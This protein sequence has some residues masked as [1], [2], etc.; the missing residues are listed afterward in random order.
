MITGSEF[1]QKFSRSSPQKW[2]QAALDEARL[3]SLTPWPVVPITLTDGNDT[4]ILGVQSDVLSIGSIADFVRMPLTTPYAQSIA[5]LS[6]SLL[7][8]PWLE[9]MIWRAAEVKLTP[10]SMEPN[11]GASLE[12]YAVHS[13]LIDNTLARENVWPGTLIAGIK[14]GV[15]VANFYKPG[16]VL[17]FGWY[18]RF[19]TKDGALTATPAPDVF[20]DGKPIGALN[21]QPIQPKSNVH[22]EGYV[23]YSHGIRLVAPTCLVNGETWETIRLY[24][25]PTL[26]R[27]VNPLAANA[28]APSQAGALFMPRYPAPVPPAPVRIASGATILGSA[29]IDTV[30]RPPGRIPFT[31]DPAEIAL[32][33][34]AAHKNRRT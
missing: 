16:K 2:E 9:Y 20:D 1:V 21:R 31:P 17:L 8:T 26:S 15:V 14:K 28:N 5:N 4:A 34:L 33:R 32:D 3:G 10:V 22:A 25:H 24:S 6:G 18:R 13:N 11:L 7:P 12:Q 29:A 30:L 23:D 19:L 27:L